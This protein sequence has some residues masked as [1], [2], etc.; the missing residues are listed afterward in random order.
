M[1]E[2][3]TVSGRRKEKN[4]VKMKI[5]QKTTTL[6][7]QSSCSTLEV[8][9]STYYHWKNQS[10]QEEDAKASLLRE[11]EN[12]S[13]ECMGYGYRRITKE[14]ERRGT[15]AN[16][17]KVLRIMRE[18]DLLC[19]PKKFKPVTTNSNHSQPLYPNLTKNLI[20]TKPNQLWVVD[21]TYI[22]LSKEFIYLATIIDI[23]SRK[24]I[25]WEL[26]RSME[27]QLP[28]NALNKAI[29]ER[30]RFGFE[31]LIHHS[32]RGAQYASNE[33]V[34][35][36]EANG[37]K[38]SMTETGNPRENAYAESFFKTLKVEEVYLKEYQDFD[39]AY[40]NIKKFIQDVYNK[41]RLHSS[42]G[43]VPPEEYEKEVLNIR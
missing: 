25:G 30:K 21:I 1:R 31:E 33:Y 4:E 37:I 36:L 41:K 10:Q 32:D 18:N 38:I 23:F 40:R 13:L 16:H 34:A 27:T 39:D 15:K 12:I 9:R 11:I 19:K 35:M 3:E 14:L 8:S 6:S 24:C 2:L 22:H 43:Y 28:L 17:K 26:G 20:V 29:L 7:I 42:I 5:I